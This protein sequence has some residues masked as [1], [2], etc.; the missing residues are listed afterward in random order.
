[1]DK[2]TILLFW[3]ITFQMNTYIF[4]HFQSSADV[5][6]LCLMVS[7]QLLRGSF[8]AQ[9]RGVKNMIYSTLSQK[10]VH[11]VSFLSKTQR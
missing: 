10:W 8:R 3:K 4:L 9:W 1:M 5:I 2:V 7:S 11:I 6:L